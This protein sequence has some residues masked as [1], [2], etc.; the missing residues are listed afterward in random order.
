MK[1]IHQMKKAHYF[2]VFFLFIQFQGLSQIEGLSFSA[3]VDAYYSYDFFKPDNHQKQYV[4]QAARHNEFN[5]NLALISASFE[6]DRYRANIGLQ[7][8]T[9]PS[10]NYAEP[11][12]LAQ[13][14]NQA[15]VGIKIGERSWLDAGV[16]GGHFGF[17]GLIS[18]DNALYTQALATEYTPYFQTGVQWTTEFDNLVFRAVIL[19]GWQN[20][21]ET[22]DAKSFGI[23]IDYQV[24]EEIAVSY[25]NY[26][27]DEGNDLI[28]E[29]YRFHNNFY[30]SYDNGKI[31]SAVVAD[32]TQQELVSSESDGTV[33]FLTWINGYEING[34]WSAGLRYEYVSDPDQILFSTLSPGFHT[35][36]ISGA[37]TYSVSQDVAVNIEGKSYY[38]EESI[39]QKAGDLS[40][41]TFMVN[42]G[43]TI[44]LE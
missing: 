40:N 20:I 28:G 30:A 9:Y 22:N 39:W 42:F 1:P 16:M 15:N 31:S 26:Y 38:G 33:V 35:N 44:R 6:S 18:L 41:S 24:N 2:G 13:M 5:I 17:E 3:Y 12:E 43:L 23:G 37:L 8:G 10:V 25:G 29:K 34:S 21:Y 32:V 36:I 4:T 7:T 19:N 14:I 11:T 27:G